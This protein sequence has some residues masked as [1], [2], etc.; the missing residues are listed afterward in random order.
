MSCRARG[1]A[2]LRATDAQGQLS[3]WPDP[4]TNSNRMHL[5]VCRHS[6]TGIA[7]VQSTMEEKVL[8]VLACAS[9]VGVSVGSVPFRDDIVTLRSEQVAI[10]TIQSNNISAIVSEKCALQSV[11]SMA[12]GT[13]PIE[14][15]E[16]FE[17]EDSWLLSLASESVPTWIGWR[18]IQLS[19]E[20]AAIVIIVNEG[21]ILLFSQQ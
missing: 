5:S 20:R 19:F 12:P 11:G 2:D 17:I 16:P 6:T 13:E 9:A 7:L 4:H 8:A 21:S 15:S 18:F 14:V 1:G 3:G 10:W